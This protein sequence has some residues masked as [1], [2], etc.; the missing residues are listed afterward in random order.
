ML[1]GEF[2][3]ILET[4]INGFNTPGFMSV[5]FSNSVESV[6]LE[7]F[8]GGEKLTEQLSGRLAN[9]HAVF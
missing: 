9:L 5:N 3:W 7:I 4:N 2:Y 6:E 8:Q 1:I